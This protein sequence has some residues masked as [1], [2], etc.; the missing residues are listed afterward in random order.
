MDSC[1]KYWDLTATETVLRGSLQLTDENSASQH[2][3]I[4]SYV[5]QCIQ[6]II[7]ILGYDHRYRCV[8]THIFH[9]RVD[10]CSTT[11]IINAINAAIVI[12]IT[13]FDSARGG[14]G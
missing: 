5:P 13:F 10:H 9:N 8:C 12:F 7:E 3:C 11:D 4:L 2:V 6:F 14:G 1:G